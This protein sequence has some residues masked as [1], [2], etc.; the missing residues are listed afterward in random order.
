M[1]YGAN[2]NGL[3]TTGDA[4]LSGQLQGPQHNHLHFH[5]EISTREEAVSIAVETLEVFSPRLL[6]A[7][8]SA[9]VHISCSAETESPSEVD[10][11]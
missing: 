9:P 10:G 8:V 5:G 6:A 1:R 2:H 11:C 7:A 4:K 3:A